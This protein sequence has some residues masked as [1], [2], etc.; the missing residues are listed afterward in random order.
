VESIWRT[1]RLHVPG[2]ANNLRRIIILWAVSLAAAGQFA[3]AQSE[4]VLH[5]FTGG[6][7]G[8]QPQAGLTMDRAGNLYG[9]ARYGGYYGGNCSSLGCGTVFELVHSG[10]SWILKSLHS[11]TG[12]N[13]GAWPVGPLYFGP[14]GALYGTT[15]NG[16]GDGYGCGTVFRL[17]PAATICRAVTCPWDETVLIS[18]GAGITGLFPYGGV[19]FDASGNLYGTTFQGGVLADCDG[20]G[21]GVVYELSH[22]NGNWVQTILYTFTGSNGAAPEAGLAFDASGNLY[23][24]TAQGGG[25]DQ[26]T[27]FR[28]SFSG[29]GWIGGPIYDFTGGGDGGGP[30]GSVIFDPAGNLYGVTAGGGAYYGGTAFEL[31]PSNGAWTETVLESF[32]GDGDGPTGPLVRGS[33][34]SLYGTTGGASGL[35]SV[36]KLTLGSGGWIYT[37]LYDF[38]GGGSGSSP[39]GGLVLDADGNLY[40]TTNLGGDQQCEPYEGC[41]VIFEVTP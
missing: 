32:Y 16:G 34:A 4:R 10:S 13:D 37:G 36:F 3:H 29:S 12:N 41:G 8:A 33:D 6:P 22:T 2:V 20:H 31:T 30:S 1:L 19:V 7:D 39:Q 28:L 26:G 38:S 35:G 21:C 9:T 11:F 14:D 24:T 5:I 40:G 18:F 17:T 15:L 27:V 23:G 25:Y